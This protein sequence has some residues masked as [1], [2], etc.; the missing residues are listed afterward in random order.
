MAYDRMAERVNGLASEWPSIGWPRVNGLHKVK[1]FIHHKRTQ[2]FLFMLVIFLAVLIVSDS[3][4]LLSWLHMDYDPML[5][6]LDNDSTR[7]GFFYLNEYH[8]T[9]RSSLYFFILDGSLFLS[10]IILLPADI[11]SSEKRIIAS[12]DKVK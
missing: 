4:C 6:A 3:A 9:S 5:I 2:Y 8:Q 11:Q 7:S 1:S 12:H 10:L